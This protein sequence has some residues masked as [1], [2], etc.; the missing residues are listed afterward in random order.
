MDDQLQERERY[1]HAQLNMLR[2]QFQRDA[3]PLIDELV[4]IRSLRTPVFAMTFDGQLIEPSRL[5]RAE[6]AA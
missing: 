5:L 3:K 4:R 2:E 1:I 6:M